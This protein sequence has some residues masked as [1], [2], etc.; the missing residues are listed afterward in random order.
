MVAEKLRK[1]PDGAR[2]PEAEL[3]VLA[4]LW[5]R[6]RATARDIREAMR[7][8]RPMTHGAMVTLLKRLEAKGW[9]ARRKGAAG[10][11]F[12][13]W[14][15]QRPQPTYRRILRDLVRRVFGGNNLALIANLVDAKPP[16]PEELDRLQ[17]LLD[18]LKG[19]NQ[20]EQD[21]GRVRPIL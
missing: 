11:A 12:V 18:D 7:P 10:K 9:V 5:Q 4:C 13:Y 16:T 1:G 15:T 3:D 6:K 17:G 19:R 14:A 20:P 2:L 8:Y 21:D